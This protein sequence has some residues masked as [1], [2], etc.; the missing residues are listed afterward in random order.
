MA[1]ADGD[2]QSVDSEVLRTVVHA[3]VLDF[4]FVRDRQIE[5]LDLLI[6]MRYL[7][8]GFTPI[9]VLYGVRDPEWAA[10]PRPGQSCGMP[11]QQPLIAFAGGFGCCGKIV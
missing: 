7:I 8:G 4:V 2:E 6:G 9:L 3:N 10:D 5:V 1:W 11:A